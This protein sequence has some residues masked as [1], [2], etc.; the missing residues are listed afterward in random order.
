M[1]AGLGA[2]EVIERVPVVLPIVT[3][4]EVVALV[5]SV[6][7]AALPSMRQLPA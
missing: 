5:T 1:A 4:C 3:F 7:D 6:V 2:L